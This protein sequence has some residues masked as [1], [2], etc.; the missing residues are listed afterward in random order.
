MK[1]VSFGAA[2]QVTGSM[3][4][5]ELDNGF[6]ILIDCGLDYESGKRSM[7][8][9]NRFF[10][11]DPAGLDLVILTHAH[12][13]HSGNL[14]NLVKQGYQG[15]ILCTPPTY[16]FCSHLLPDSVNVQISELN[17]NSSRG[18]K[19]K[20]KPVKSSDLLY[21]LKD[22]NET[23]QRMVTFP[24]HKEIEITEDCYATFIPSG[25]ILGAASVIIR[26]VESGRETSIGFTG[27]LG[28]RHANLVVDPERMQGIQYLVC[29][30]TYGGKYH[31]DTESPEDILMKHI[32]STCIDKR[33]RLII[34]AFSV[35]R[36]Q[37]IVYS[38]NKLYKQGRFEGIRVYVD[39]PLAIESTA[40]YNKHSAFLNEEARTFLKQHKSLFNFPLLMEVE[41]LKDSEDMRS[42]YEPS[43][44]VSAAGMVEG[45]RI[46]EHVYNNLQNPYSTILI[47]GY[48]AEGTLGWQL[49]QPDPYVSIRGKQIPKYCTIAS[50]DIF[51][52]HP[53]H[54]SLVDYVKMYD[55]GTL[56]KVF[57]VH[58]ELKS[59]DAF[60]DAL[61]QEGYPSQIAEK[62]KVYML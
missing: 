48:C 1:Y 39:S 30:S 50:T 19:K 13:D 47:A 5:I 22:V 53:G 56:R 38:L 35:G 27:D 42:D 16:D 20:P 32:Q 2:Q 29:E 59:L 26:A 17:K 18:K 54:Q 8:D 36:T 6:R 34:P 40:I 55:A 12:I 52:S 60:T 14:P 3:H 43:I 57:L 62:D 24:F 25:H 45:G 11:F 23:L 4:L 61:K 7:T 46:V 37:A 28:R 9:T 44:I 21:G 15:Q 31:I 49:K 33:G 41:S 58:G 10:E 51:S